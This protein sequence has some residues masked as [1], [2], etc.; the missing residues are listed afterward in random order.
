[1]KFYVIVVFLVIKLQSFHDEWHFI[2]DKF[3][4]K[5]SVETYSEKMRQLYRK[6]PI[7]DVN[8]DAL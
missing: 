3:S 4:S 5:R 6:T 2:G 1:M 8:K 7:H